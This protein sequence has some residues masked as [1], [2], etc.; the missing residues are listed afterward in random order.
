MWVRRL[1]YWKHWSHNTESDS[2]RPASRRHHLK[3]STRPAAM[4]RQSQNAWCRSPTA[5][6]VAPPMHITINTAVVDTPVQFIRADLSTS[7]T[8][9]AGAALPPGGKQFVDSCKLRPHLLHIKVEGEAKTTGTHV[10]EAPRI[11]QEWANRCIRK[12]KSHVAEDW[13][14]KC[15]PSQKGEI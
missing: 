7:G 6:T 13:P 4:G 10:A 5:A 8:A 15:Q 11:A 9:C 1:T 14:D 3:E 12:V 2:S